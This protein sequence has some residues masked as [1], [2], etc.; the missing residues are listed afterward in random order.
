M[1][2]FDRFSIAHGV[3]AINFRGLQCDAGARARAGRSEGKAPTSA[4]LGWPGV[5]SRAIFTDHAAVRGSRREGRPQKVHRKSLTRGGIRSKVTAVGSGNRTNHGASARRKSAD[6][7]AEGDSSVSGPA[8]KTDSGES[9]SDSGPEG[10]SFFNAL[11]AFAVRFRI[12]DYAARQSIQGRYAATERAALV[13]R[14]G[15]QDFFAGRHWHIQP[16]LVKLRRSCDSGSGVGFHRCL[17]DQLA[18]RGIQRVGIALQVAE[19]YQVFPWR[20]PRADTYCRA[21]PSS[22]F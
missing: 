12:P 21:Q 20:F 10:K 5:P 13:V 16:V 19:V 17:P 18:I 2:N 7:P 9:V 15:C 11:N 22:C 8:G 4:A 6:S 3:F 1:S 14:V